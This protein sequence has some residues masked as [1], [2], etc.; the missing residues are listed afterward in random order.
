LYIFIRKFVR[1]VVK[2]AARVVMGSACVPIVVTICRN[3]EAF[4]C[5]SNNL[6]IIERATGCLLILSMASMIAPQTFSSATFRLLSVSFS[7]FPVPVTVPSNPDKHV[8]S[9]S[10]FGSWR[11]L[12]L[13]GFL[14]KVM[15]LQKILHGFGDGSSHAAILPSTELVSG[16][17][18]ESLQWRNQ[19]LVDPHN[20][21]RRLHNHHVL[22]LRYAFAILAFCYLNVTKVLYSYPYARYVGQIGIKRR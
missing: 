4:I 12:A 6:T 9:W 8:T 10:S 2:D 19:L 1:S 11:K 14:R 7:E 22:F 20:P 16:L 17:G 5:R 18:D 13:L 3:P 21:T 15:F